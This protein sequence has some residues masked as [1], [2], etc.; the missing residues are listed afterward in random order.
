MKRPKTNQKPKSSIRSIAFAL[1]SLTAFVIFLNRSDVA[2]EYM[3]KGLGLCGAAVIPSLF[4]FMVI[5]E[6]VIQ[7]PAIYNICKIFRRPMKRLFNVS[8]AGG[9]AFI[10]GVL[11][12]FPIG[13]KTAISA[14]DSGRI[15]KDELSRLLCFCNNP[16]SA[17]VISVVGISLF[18]SK[19]IGVIMYACVIFSSV[20]VGILSKFL[21][22]KKQ[23]AES[24]ASFLPPTDI[25]TIGIFT[26]AV[27][28]SALS[29]LT[30]CAYVVF[31][32]SLVGCIGDILSSTSAPN[33]LSTLIFGFFE[34]SSGVQAAAGTKNIEAAI[35]LAAAFVAWSGISVHCQIITICAGRGL[36]FR[37]YFVSK[38][39]QSIICAF[40]MG[41]A[42]KHFFADAPPI[43]EDVFMGGE[44]VIS[45][46]NSL[47]YCFSFFFASVFGVGIG[48]K[49]NKHKA[50]QGDDK[51]V[52]K[53]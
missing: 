12:G 20:A 41:L 17:F 25:D 31:F 45:V 40:F 24:E 13:A 47:F 52:E 10:L 36:S 34:I 49:P 15:S 46:A 38:V 44:D 22:S 51:K 18:G 28:K 37:P 5:S 23:C 1:L 26:S 53:I 29:M 9:C 6:L 39:S 48:I 4:P 11:C 8:E 42:L 16:G 21:S 27:S 35:I 32:S 33:M 14:Y 30:V 3:K 19:R 43:S 7:S 50:F 2:I